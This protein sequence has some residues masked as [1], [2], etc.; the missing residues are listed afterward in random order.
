L[1]AAGSFWNASAGA[2]RNRARNAA[3][4]QADRN[5]FMRGL[6]VRWRLFLRGRSVHAFFQERQECGKR[7]DRKNASHPSPR[8]KRIHTI[9]H[10]PPRDFAEI[11]DE[12]REFIRIG[13]LWRTAVFQI[14]HPLTD[15]WKNGISRWRI[16]YPGFAIVRF[17][18]T[19]RWGQTAIFLIANWKILIDQKAHYLL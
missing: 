4:V 2:E 15:Q 16:L 17:R 9:V 12:L 6:L 3:R 7:N 18:K 13:A 8:E 11:E 19:F 10:P 1:A 14:V 5:G